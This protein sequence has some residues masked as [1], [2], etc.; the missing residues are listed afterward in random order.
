MARAVP[1]HRTCE[2]EVNPDPLSV[3]V[4]AVDPASTLEGDKDARDGAGLGAGLS[5]KLS[6][7][8]VPPP[9]AGVSTVT[10]AVPAVP[11]SEAGTWACRLVLD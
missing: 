7:A 11:R 5:V 4:N 8:E 2:L 6:A 9:G 3:R 10:L 1:F